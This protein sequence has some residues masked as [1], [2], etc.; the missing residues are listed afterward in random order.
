LTSK[1]FA[2][3]DLADRFQEVVGYDLYEQILGRKGR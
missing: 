2:V 1:L 3:P